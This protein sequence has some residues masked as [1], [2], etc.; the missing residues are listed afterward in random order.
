M[1]QTLHRLT[2]TGPVSVG[3]SQVYGLWEYNYEKGEDGR[4]RQRRWTVRISIDEADA[5][6]LFPYQWVQLQLPGRSAVQAF[7]Q[8]GRQAPPF[9]LLSFER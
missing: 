6:G 4:P 8:G 9:V 7:Y 1:P 5:L 2:G 3:R